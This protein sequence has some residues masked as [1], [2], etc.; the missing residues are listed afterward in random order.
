MATP[1]SKE[2]RRF[3]RAARK[4]REEARCLLANG[5]TTGA[6]YL[7]GYGNECVLKALILNA[8]PMSG[9]AAVLATFRGNR[10]H[11]LTWLRDGYAAAGRPPPPREVS[12]DILFVLRW[13]TGLRYDPKRTADDLAADFLAATDRIFDWADGRL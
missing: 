6:V 2:A 9:E 7:A 3:Y 12:A 8:T 1:S 4:R 13:T 10:G 5:F 11:S